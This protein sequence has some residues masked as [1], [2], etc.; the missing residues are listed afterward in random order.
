[1]WMNH[2]FTDDPAAG[3]RHPSWP[4]NW[5]ELDELVPELNMPDTDPLF[6]GAETDPWPAGLTRP[7]PVDH[8]HSVCIDPL[9]IARSD[10]AIQAIPP[11]DPR[12]SLPD[13]WPGRAFP[14][15]LDNDP[16]NSSTFSPTVPPPLLG[17]PRMSRVSLRS[18]QSPYAP[19]MSLGLADRV[20]R[21]QDDLLFELPTDDTLRPT[22]VTD[23]LQRPQSEG[24][25][26]WMATLTPVEGEGDAAASQRRLFNYSV[27]VFYK[28]NLD[29]PVGVGAI[30]DNDLSWRLADRGQRPTERVVFADFL[31]PAVSFGGGDVR[32]RLV[33]MPGATNNDVAD[34]DRNDF[35]NIRPGNWILLSGYYTPVAAGEHHAAFQWYR[36]VAVDDGPTLVEDTSITASG[37]P[38]W[39]RDVTLAGPDWDASA[40]EDADGN[41]PTFARTCYATLVEGVVAVF[42]KT[43]EL[44]T[45]A[46]K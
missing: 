6:P 19:M 30:L 9:F 37:Q 7:S 38:E 23:L 32:L 36:V 17:P 18:W 4:Q 24:N 3:N 26:S 25:Y 29:M 43:V 44:D 35:T 31:S 16:G 11:T 8:G 12:A 22:A 2:Q 33:V 45:S 20:F 28:R 14:Y 27:V 34:P 21:W 13:Y 5:W 10:Q 39:L 40:F 46:R 41:A 15:F 42:T 1:T